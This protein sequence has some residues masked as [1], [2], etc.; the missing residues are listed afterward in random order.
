VSTPETEAPAAPVRRKKRA[1][2][3]VRFYERRDR[4]AL[5]KICADTGFLGS[6]IDP[7]FQ[8]R[9][10]F[11]DYLTGY[12]L[13]IE[14]ESTVVLEVEGVVAG[15]VMASTQ[16]G[17]HHA[18]DK[19]MLP[20]LAAKGLW[21]YVTRPYNEATKDY[22]K[23]I[24]T[25]GGKETP[26]APENMAHFHFNVLPYA[27]KVAHTRSMVDLLFGELARRGVPAIYAQMVA[28]EKR[29]GDRMFERY[30]FKRHSECEVTKYRKFTDQRIYLFTIVKDLSANAVLYGLDLAKD[31]A[32]SENG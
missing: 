4:D 8:D 1:D 11:A 15:Y 32:A 10:L 3:T 25:R 17:L 28:Y 14:P 6:P 16:P 2:F 12:Y 20:V 5:R 21:R 13:D 30:G 9:E 23:W 26:E 18:Y 31:K 24:L 7:V 27:R 29:R 22:I 19:L